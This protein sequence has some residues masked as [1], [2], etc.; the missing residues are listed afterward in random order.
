MTNEIIAISASNTSKFYLSG[1]TKEYIDFFNK[2]YLQHASE[3]ELQKVAPKEVSPEAVQP[4]NTVESELKSLAE[5][6]AI[7][8]KEQETV[9]NQAADEK[10]AETKS[11]QSEVATETAPPVVVQPQEQN[12]VTPAPAE[13]PVKAEK[14]SIFSD[15]KVEKH[16]VVILLRKTRID[17]NRIQKG[18]A[19]HTRNN[20]GTSHNVQL[21]DFGSS[22]RL[23]QIDGFSNADEAQAYIK[24]IDDYPYLIRDFAQ[25]EHY[26]W[27]ISESNMSKLQETQDVDT[28]EAFFKSNYQK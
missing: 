25:K 2:Y 14:P 28:Y 24:S 19:A 13:E 5:N 20:F 12:A 27:A 18:F 3:D 11:K 22:Y 9:N 15:T 7:D 16:L 4:E 17:Y 8:P 6:T 23:V 1:L 26:I 21:L 10:Q